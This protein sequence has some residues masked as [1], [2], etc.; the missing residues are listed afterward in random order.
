MQKSYF[1][2]FRNYRKGK[3]EASMNFEVQYA[4]A[5]KTVAPVGWSHP[6]SNTETHELLFCTHGKIYIGLGF[7]RFV[8]SEGEA[9]I[10]PAGTRRYGFRENTETAEFYWAHFSGD[11]GTLPP[12]STPDAERTERLFGELILYSRSP[13]YDDEACTCALRLVLF[14]MMR[15]GAVNEDAPYS[16]L[17]AICEWISQNSDRPLRVSD[18]AA[19]FNYNEDYITRLFKVHYKPGVKSYIDAV[20]IKRIRELLLSTDLKIKEISEKMGFANTKAFHK[21]FKY[22]ENISAAA[23][24]ELYFGS[25]TKATFEEE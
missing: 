3:V 23:F 21:F 2:G 15:A 8:L 13:E 10:L 6:S 5:G 9:A 14:E 25:G 16:K 22:H 4:V 19:A 20:R 18:V 24:R 17:F 12:R 7:E 11:L 1:S